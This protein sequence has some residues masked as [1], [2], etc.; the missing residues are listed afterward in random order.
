MVGNKWVFKLKRSAYG[1]ALYWARLVAKGFT[2]KFGIDYEETFSPV[3]RRC[4]LRVLVSLAVNLDLAIYHCDV[5]T[6]FLYGYL[7]ETIYM[8]QPDGFTSK[9]NEDKSLQTM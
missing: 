9:G 5:K 6:A 1:I 8:K 2:Q 3:V 7:K 4:T